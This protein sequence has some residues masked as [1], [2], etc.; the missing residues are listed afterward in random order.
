MT[1]TACDYGTATCTLCNADCSMEL[2]LM[3]NI[4]GDGVVSPGD[5]EC[6]DGDTD[7]DDGCDG[8]CNEEP[9]WT[10]T[11]MMPSTCM[12]TCG[13]GIVAGTEECDDGDTDDDDGC[14]SGCA[15]EAGWDCTGTMPTTCTETCGDG[16]VVGGE[17]CDDNNT[18]ACGLCSAACTVSRTAAAAT[19]SITAAGA[20]DTTDNGTFTLDDGVNPAVTFGLDS[21]PGGGT[22]PGT[23]INIQGLSASQA[24]LTIAGAINATSSLDITATPPA[25]GPI[26]MLANDVIGEDGNV[27][28]TSSM[29]SSPW[30]F[31][32]ME[33]GV[34]RTCGGGIGCTDNNDCESAM[35]MSG[36]CTAP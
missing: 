5:E 16:M 11:G 8:S 22:P 35:C 7:A 36:S 29:L 18:S 19:G 3:G 1:E 32:G 34:G 20:A 6:D 2:M 21:E 24:A 14:D 9:G 10:C 30:D 12:T 17:A 28:I 27:A 15:E 31:V 26:V 33:N 13:D 4:C 23:P 25:S